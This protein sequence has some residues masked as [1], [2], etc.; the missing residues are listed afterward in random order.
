MPGPYSPF[1]DAPA[2]PERPT[3][4]DCPPTRSKPWPK[5]TGEPSL[6][7]PAPSGPPDTGYRPLPDRGRVE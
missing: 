2:R 4:P 3:P 7:C 6:P 1:P 5:P